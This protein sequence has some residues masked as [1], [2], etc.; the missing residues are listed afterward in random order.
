MS[1]HGLFSE[2]SKEDFDSR[3]FREEV[4]ADLGYLL[5][6]VS[7]EVA[8]G[9]WKASC[10]WFVLRQADSGCKEKEEAQSSTISASVP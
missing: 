10:S 5:G 7:S 4:T 9:K 1:G 6:A 3:S 8:A 2:A